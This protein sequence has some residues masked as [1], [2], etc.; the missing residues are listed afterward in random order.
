MLTHTQ[1]ALAVISKPAAS[2]CSFWE[3]WEKGKSQLTSS[4][5]SAWTQ[6]FREEW[7]TL[8]ATSELHKRGVITRIYAR[9][10]Q[11]WGTSSVSA[12][13]RQKDIFAKHWTEH[14]SLQAAFQSMGP[15]CV[16][17]YVPLS[18]ASLQRGLSGFRVE[19][20]TAPIIA[21]EFQGPLS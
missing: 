6:G 11:Q 20:S 3:R 9:W 19:I 17:V 2:P 18:W 5:C 10:W 13:S 16:C 4:V 8:P 1:N 14:S 15:G 12:V 21:L 7:E